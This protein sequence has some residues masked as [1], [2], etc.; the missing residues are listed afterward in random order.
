MRGLF[1]SAF[2]LI[3]TSDATIQT[4]NE[5]S[6]LLNP[7]DSY[8]AT[9]NGYH[10][11]RII[12]DAYDN[13]RN[14]SSSTR[15]RM[16][17]L[18][19]SVLDDMRNSRME[20]NFIPLRYTGGQIIAALSP[21]MLMRYSPQRFAQSIGYKY[22]VPEEFEWFYVESL[23][24]YRD[25]ADGI[26]KA[27]NASVSARN[28]M[29]APY[30]GQTVTVYTNDGRVGISDGRNEQGRPFIDRLPA[31][32][33]SHGIRNENV[34][35]PMNRFQNIWGT[36]VVTMG[37]YVFG[38]ADTLYGGTQG[39]ESGINTDY[40]GFMVEPDRHDDKDIYNGNEPTILSVTDGFRGGDYFKFYNYNK[41]HDTIYENSGIYSWF[42]GHGPSSRIFGASINNTYHLPLENTQLSLYKYAYPNMQSPTVF[43]EKIENDVRNRNYNDM[44][45]FNEA[46]NEIKEVVKDMVLLFIAARVANRLPIPIVRGA[47]KSHFYKEL[48]I[49]VVELVWA[50]VEPI[51]HSDYVT[52]L[53]WKNS[54]SKGH[55][56]PEYLN[57]NVLTDN[58]TVWTMNIPQ[59]ET[60]RT[61]EGK[62]IKNR[63]DPFV[64][65]PV[66]RL[67]K[68]I[69]EFYDW[70]AEEG[71]MRNP[72]TGLF[73]HSGKRAPNMKVNMEPWM[74]TEYNEVWDKWSKGYHIAMAHNI[75]GYDRR[76]QNDTD[77]YYK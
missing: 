1:P 77:I 38:I 53:Q 18:I 68:S 35:Y 25:D 66:N 55:K 46:M 48:G 60:I 5:S 30:T 4:P 27:E 69:K 6:I 71:M 62:S 59:T 15:V 17:N 41:K 44:V 75:S 74:D 47:L 43:N 50:G 73:S 14:Y 36:Q 10:D 3:F 26:E 37:Q 31:L 33:P 19:P 20:N 63:K 56:I 49:K 51:L 7:T 28:Y 2:G 39:W 70:L 8:K 24:V 29:S 45:L 52:T 57:G 42:P 16:P 22:E 12:E 67:F 65:I 40:G 76:P 13:I 58:Y 34:A 11:Y 54:Y 9:E 32:N 64:T 61:V 21:E 72:P 23:E